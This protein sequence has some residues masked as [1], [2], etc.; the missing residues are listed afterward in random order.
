M[1][2]KYIILNLSKVLICI[3]FS[4]SFTNKQNI[5]L[6]HSVNY[7]KDNVII[8]FLDSESC[9][10]VNY[11]IHFNSFYDTINKSILKFIKIN[12]NKIFL[13]LEKSQMAIPIGNIDSII[14]NN[15]NK[16]NYDSKYYSRLELVLI[17]NENG[18]VLFKGQGFIHK[19]ILDLH[20]EFFKVI[21]KLNLEFEPA[22][23][24]GKNVSSI[25]FIDFVY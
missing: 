15:F 12:N 14:R 1:N 25:F 4:V 23:I 2:G 6:I 18:K 11:E 24:N 9:C 3:F 22:K 16:V 20:K 5:D 13:N 17:L 10:E 21:N 8:K 7:N 19:P